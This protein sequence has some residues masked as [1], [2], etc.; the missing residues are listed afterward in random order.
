M[1]CD[2]NRRPLPDLEAN[3]YD[4]AVFIGVLEYVRDVPSV[5]D[6]LAPRV[7]DCV[8][9]YVCANVS[10]YSLRGMTESFRRL[11]MGWMNNY[12][13]EQ[14]RALFDERGFV[15]VREAMWGNNRLFLFSKRPSP[16]ALAHL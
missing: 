4:V 11:K 7:S 13:E 15:H 6:W 12:R 9:S 5:L 14:I 2:L 1:I 10:R 3:T 16:K 8:M